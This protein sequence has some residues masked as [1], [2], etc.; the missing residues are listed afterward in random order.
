M[1]NGNHNYFVSMINAGLT[2]T[3]LNLIRVSLGDAD[4][5]TVIPVSGIDGGSITNP[6]LY[7]PRRKIIIAYDSAN[8]VICGFQY[9]EESGALSRIWEKTGFC[10]G[11]HMVYYPDTGEVVTNDYRRFRDAAVVLDVESGE[12][13]GRVDLQSFSQGVVFPGPGWERDFYYLTFS[14]ITRVQ[15][16]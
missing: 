9:D 3:P 5:N 16:R 10:C 7:C 12:E 14:S 15:V 11:G 4:S 2:P 6:P 1:D 8:R 13:K